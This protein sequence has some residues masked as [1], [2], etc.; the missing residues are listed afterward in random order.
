MLTFATNAT[1][2]SQ[3]C[4]AR[5]DSVLGWMEDPVLCGAHPESGPDGS[6]L[7]SCLAQ[8]MCVASMRLELAAKLKGSGPT[9]VLQQRWLNEPA[10]D[11]VTTA[12][13]LADH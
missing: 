13:S 9:V 7:D 6:G 3:I 11:K 4:P 8:L 10:S 1:S 2:Q 5:Y 12:E